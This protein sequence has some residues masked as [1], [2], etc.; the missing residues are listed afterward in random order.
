MKISNIIVALA[1]APLLLVRVTEASLVCS[2]GAPPPSFN[3]ECQNACSTGPEPGGRVGP[4]AFFGS[5]ISPYDIAAIY[6]GLQSWAGCVDMVSTMISAYNGLPKEDSERVFLLAVGPNS[7]KD[8]NENFCQGFAA[9]NDD[10][11]DTWIDEWDANQRD[12]FFYKKTDPEDNSSWEFYGRYSMN[13]HKFVFS[14]TIQEMLKLV[15]SNATLAEC[16]APT[17]FPV[18]APSS[19]PDSAS[20]SLSDS[21]S[22]SSSNSIPFLMSSAAVLAWSIIL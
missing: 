9:C 18:S 16:S 4:G 10:V 2:D 21:A 7:Y 14:D 17:S 3:Q 6:F 20:S 15:G 8:D 11:N 1:A 22:S 12:V 13:D 19:F 5:E